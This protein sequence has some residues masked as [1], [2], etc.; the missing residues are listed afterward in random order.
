M[1]FS[2]P[3]DDKN[4]FFEILGNQ[5]RP[6]VPGKQPSYVYSGPNENIDSGNQDNQWGT[7]PFGY[8]QY[9][10]PKKYDRNRGN[11]RE[12]LCGCNMEVI[13]ALLYQ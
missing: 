8:S 3:D 4:C 6:S 9:V 12:F 5:I 13:R 11:Q 1:Q 2:N 10:P 7:K